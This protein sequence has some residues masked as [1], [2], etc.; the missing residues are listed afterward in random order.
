MLSS[1]EIT[2]RLLEALPPELAGDVNLRI[3]LEPWLA[4]A[5]SDPAYLDFLLRRQEAQVD[6]G[7]Q[8]AALALGA[9]AFR[10][11]DCAGDPQTWLLS[12][13]SGRLRI[14]AAL[15]RLNGKA[16][17]LQGADDL[18]SLAELA[19]TC[20]G[21]Q[22]ET[23][24][25][26]QS[27]SNFLR[28]YFESNR[29]DLSALLIVLFGSVEQPFD[30]LKFGLQYGAG[31]LG[32]RMLLS[33]ISRRALLENAAHYIHDLDNKQRLDLAE[34][35][36]LADQIEIAQAVASVET[37]PF[38]T[39]DAV[40]P[41]FSADIHSATQQASTAMLAGMARS[42][43]AFEKINN[44]LQA[45]QNIGAALAQQ[46]ARTALHEGDAVTAVAANEQALA[47]GD[48]DLEI[49]PDLAQ[50]FVARGQPENALRLLRAD[51]LTDIPI[52]LA[53]RI[54]LARSLAL[55]A[56]NLEKDT[57]AALATALD[58]CGP[59]DT[60]GVMPRDAPTLAGLAALA[61][62]IGLTRFATGYLEHVVAALPAS[63]S[64]NHN[65]AHSFLNSDDV[66][67]AR[68]A[69]L[70]ALGL[71]PLRADAQATYAEALMAEGENL[72]PDPQRALRHWERALELEPTEIEY[73][74][75]MATCALESSQIDLARTTAEK[76]LEMSSTTDSSNDNEQ[77]R[78]RAHILLGEV[79]AQ[80]G[81][82]SSAFDHFQHAT[83]IAPTY[84]EAWRAVA[85][86]HQRDEKSE[87][88]L[89]ALEAGRQ[90][91]GDSNLIDSAALLADLGAL[92]SEAGNATEAL[93]ALEAANRAAPNNA[94]YQARYG[95]ALFDQGHAAE[96]ITALQNAARLSPSDPKVWQDLARAQEKCGEETEALT[97]YEQ[98]LSA[99]GRGYEISNE[100][101][102]LALRLGRHDIALPALV[103][104]AEYPQADADTFT[105]LGT[106]NEEREDYK[107]AIEA[108][109]RVVA[110][111]PGRNDILVRLGKC[112]LKT[113]QA[114][115]A[116][117][118][119]SDAAQQDLDDLELQTT[120][121]NAFVQEELWDEA[122][123]SF[124]NTTRI[125]P[126][127]SYRWKDLGRVAYR[128][129][130]VE[131]AIQA[132]EHA[133]ELS[134]ENVEVIIELGRLYTAE[135]NWEAAK[136]TLE[137]T[138]EFDG[139]QPEVHTLLAR[140]L[141]N[142][143][144]PGEA[145][146]AL[147]RAETLAPDDLEIIG[148]LG[149]LQMAQVEFESAHKTFLR[150]VDIC[151]TLDREPAEKA[152]F[153]CL[154]GD[155][156][157]HI[158]QEAHA[159]AL[160]Q[161]ALQFAPDD[162][163]LLATV[164]HSYLSRGRSPEALELL[165]HALN[166]DPT[167]VSRYI[168]AAQAAEA[169]GDRER[170]IFHLKRAIE[171]EPEDHDIAMQLAELLLRN[172]DP[173]NALAHLEHIPEGSTNGAHLNAIRGSANAALGNVER[174][175]E[176]SEQAIREAPDDLE[177]LLT[178][179]ETLIQTGQI[180]RA[181][182]VTQ[183]I[184]ASHLGSPQA[185]LSFARALV[186]DA[187]E[188]I[189]GQTGDTIW[190][191]N[192]APERNNLQLITTVLDA[193]SNNAQFDNEARQL[194]GRAQAALGE[195]DVAMRQLEAVMNDHPSPEV[196][197]ALAIATRRSGNYSEARRYIES[198]QKLAP[199]HIPGRIEFGRITFLE[200]ELKIAKATFERTVILAP[201]NGA[202]H[203][204]LGEINLADN[205]I[206][207]AEPA[208][209]RALQ[210]EPHRADWQ[211]RLADIY[212][213]Q[214][215]S[216]AAMAHEQRAVHLAR[217][218][219]LPAQRS[220]QYTAA[221]AEL[222]AEDGDANAARK[223]YEAALE[224]VDSN[225]AWLSAAAAACLASGEPAQAAA[226]YERALAI[227]PQAISPL[228]GAT[229]AYM[230]LG[231]TEAAEERIQ[232][233]IRNDP[234]NAEALIVFGNFYANQQ[235]FDRALEAYESAAELTRDPIP[236]RLAIGEVLLN[237]GRHHDAY[238]VLDQALAADDSNDR[239]W[240]L[241]ATASES[242]G[243]PEAALEA[244]RRASEAAPLKATYHLRQ[245]KLC[246]SVGN[247]DQALVHLNRAVELQ[248][249]IAEGAAAHFEIG[250]IFEARRQLERALE[251]YQAAIERNPEV[252]EYYYHAGMI[253]KQMRDYVN[254]VR[255]FEIA[256]EKDKKNLDARRQL[257]A[258]SALSLINEG[259][260][261]G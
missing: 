187:E 169:A 45:I 60:P 52:S 113:G 212:R 168:E 102:S 143:G 5:F 101:G 107:A 12:T 22:R 254:A 150:A 210:L 67:K 41:G 125:A 189:A 226:Y 116:I 147:Q 59:E 46:L 148:K 233:A 219:D 83:A 75:G 209:Q 111:A 139:L 188:R 126:D 207:A 30:L 100:L 227:A 214:G 2:S 28:E 4:A 24:N 69:A 131:R 74:F 140:S 53:L 252:P 64:A 259:A 117:A 152:H 164:G 11:E 71:S 215:N 129:G 237:M 257:A 14:Q 37:E 178:A 170:A 121:A 20:V 16:A 61:A 34:E 216:S 21:L 197:T 206:E 243:D 230:A 42:A 191:A 149:A 155:A 65:L 161:R 229:K 223:E 33:N 3:S 201:H 68:Q 177:V 218:N 89:A 84:P 156:L 175:N 255:M 240:A 96:S 190:D 241:R 231:R 47:I 137:A 238:E 9:V 160:W 184:Y 62:Q 50:A 203:Y 173:D 157:T 63:Y 87:R 25:S 85:R 26:G 151:E 179:S 10:E 221:L 213:M 97:A 192:P 165:E 217:V 246:H 31:S 73:I 92:H 94:S 181:L 90:S 123:L 91:I 13:D 198:V 183:K 162:P 36:A 82:Q 222:Y 205:N 18:E 247:L 146:A 135:E 158:G 27:W 220:A 211:H 225:A 38:A 248:Q 136:S 114:S 253:S 199:S 260:M 124:E 23:K 39:P 194:R 159:V 132:L 104:A 15:A 80:I 119:L 228:I 122:L 244:Y 239:A 235:K 142:L 93:A 32:V 35:F 153:L 186:L 88:A 106:V 55:K 167:Q 128:A 180:A 95:R 44:A 200:G 86:H 70:R 202:A 108:Y 78:S 79:L 66:D 242:L 109:Q 176:L 138:L 145:L 6:S 163:D 127:E 224:L 56:L 236:V 251:S 249:S 110:L 118:A 182:E 174:A 115:A 40:N 51:D 261:V 99:G 141:T 81:E 72:M 185:A 234:E 19:A 7:W 58:L 112:C 17:A 195:P 57:E 166:C 245:G 208:M 76:A 250:R 172:D 8:P 105:L 232:E 154:A 98:A 134:P 43:T 204:W 196:L 171:Q 54:I 1:S 256:V 133:I 120:I 144:N 49:L 77:T 48:D 103:A 29:K 193:V 258:V 130:Q